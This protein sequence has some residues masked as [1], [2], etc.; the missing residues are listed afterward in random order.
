MQLTFVKPYPDFIGKRSAFVA[1]GNGPASYVTGGDLVTSA[2]GQALGGPFDYYFDAIGVDLSIS[3][4]YYG[5][6][7][8][9]GV[10]SRQTWKIKWFVTATN[11][12]VAAAVNLSAEQLTIFGFGGQY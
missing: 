8:A 12:E 6:A 9:A 7:I 11:A 3:G 10:G 4:T 5:H 2:T 1:Y